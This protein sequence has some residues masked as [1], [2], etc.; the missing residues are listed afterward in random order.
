[1]KKYS[2]IAFAAGIG[3]AGAFLL[4][5]AKTD[6]LAILT[7]KQAFSTTVSLKPGEYRKISAQDLPKPGETPSGRT[8][9][10]RGAQRP[11][12]AMPQAPAGFQVGIFVAEGLTTPRQI[13]RAPN[14]D[15]FVADTSREGGVHIF[16]GVTADGK[17]Q[18]SSLFASFPQAFGINFYPPGPTPQWVYVS[19]TTTVV[20]YPYKNGDLKATGDPETL[21]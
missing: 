16:R 5:A 7:G 21:I 18:Q 20:R 13:R 3:L 14:G 9:G 11:G 1:M 2:W 4:Q 8:P 15:V 17:P 10:G 19:S 6:G 12:N